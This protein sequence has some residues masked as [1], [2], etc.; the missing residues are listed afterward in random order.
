M[1]SVFVIG[2]FMMLVTG[3]E[4]QIPRT[5]SGHFEYTGEMI[6]DNMP[7]A[8]EKARAFFNQPFLV[9]W[10]TV[11]QAG[12]I[13]VTGRGHINVKAKQHGLSI[14]SLVPVSLQFSIEVQNGHYNYRVNHFVVDSKA[15]NLSFPLE[16]KPD[17]LRST[18]YDQLL[19]NT[20]K[21]VSSVI[22]WLKRY[23]EN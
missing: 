23:M 9:H 22:G 8:M 16:D 20:H 11:A 1:R 12:N 21:R 14:P 10:D 3:T 6:A 17:G 2:V 19:Q 5:T 4:G 13:L 7:I 18:V 15:Y